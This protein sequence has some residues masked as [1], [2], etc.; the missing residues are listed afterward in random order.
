M[1]DYLS[2]RDLAAWAFALAGDNLDSCLFADSA[3]IVV[4][5]PN[6]KSVAYSGRLVN[7]PGIDGRR[8]REREP[9]FSS[10]LA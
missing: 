8:F 1:P 9:G 6:A 5:A 7:R 2:I 3:R 4:Y 10:P